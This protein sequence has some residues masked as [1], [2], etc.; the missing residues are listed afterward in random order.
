M[1]LETMK[2][3]LENVIIIKEIVII[4]K[5]VVESIQ[6]LIKK[7]IKTCKEIEPAHGYGLQPIGRCVFQTYNLLI[8]RKLAPGQYGLEPRETPQELAPGESLP[9]PLDFTEAGTVQLIISADVSSNV[10]VRLAI[11]NAQG[12]EIWAD[13]PST[14]IVG[15]RLLD[16]EAPGSYE[17]R[18]EN[19]SSATASLTGRLEVIMCSDPAVRSWPRQYIKS[20]I[21]YATL[22]GVKTKTAP[23]GIAVYGV[24]KDGGYIL[25]TDAVKGVAYIPPDVSA[26]GYRRDGSYYGQAFSVQLNAFV[27]AKLKDGTAQYYWVRNIVGFKENKIPG[28]WNKIWRIIQRFFKYKR[29]KVRNYIEDVTTATSTLDKSRV[30]G[31]GKIYN[32]P[33]GPGNY[34]E[35]VMRGS[36]PFGRIELETWVC[37]DDGKI[38]VEFYANGQK[39]D[40]VTIRPYAPATSAYIEIA[41]TTTSAGRP[42]DLMLV[43]GGYDIGIPWAFLNAGQ[44]GLEL[45]VRMNGAWVPPPSAWSVGYGTA[46]RSYASVVPQGVGSAIVKPG[47]PNSQQLWAGT[48]IATPIG[49]NIITSTDLSSYASLNLGNGTRLIL[50]GA[51][52]NGRPAQLSSLSNVPLG[53]IVVLQYKRQYFVSISAPGNRTTGWFDEN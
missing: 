18:I 28:V 31:K 27:I 48:I 19:P 49:F 45:Y 17:L 41:P 38:I 14:R 26:S 25:T 20:A 5:D 29:L 8:Y 2:G 44:I 42:L 46:E 4:I 30:R 15:D 47:P 16:L 9:I 1:S 36:I 21:K 32:K 43:F 11:Y 6:Q 13:R 10:P 33:A 51:Y 53:S 12:E 24:K 22:N 39:Y 35:Y 34:Y 52:I 50:T 40:E 7:D 37:V 23:M 3:L